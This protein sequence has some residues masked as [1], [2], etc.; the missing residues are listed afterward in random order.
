MEDGEDLRA[1][2][3]A[4]E[5][6]D[7]LDSFLQEDD[8]LCVIKLHAPYCKACRAFGIK[9]RKIAMEKGD[10]IN[11]A[12]EKV[13][14][15]DARFGAI[16]YASNVK[17]C[18]NLGV[19]KFPTVLIFRGGE[20][21]TGGGRGEKL[22]EIVCKQSAVEDIVG[23]IDELLSMKEDED[24]L[25]GIVEAYDARIWMLFGDKMEWNILQNKL[26]SRVQKITLK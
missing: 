14:A 19:K 5:K 17:L 24:V 16:D 6:P 9:F 3:T 10:L 8:R 20:K 11:T 4:I 23:E 2:I 26:Y 15:G 7:G 21:G 13:R 22:R 12:K 1:E 18:K 25:G